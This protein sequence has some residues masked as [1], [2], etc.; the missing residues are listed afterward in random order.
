MTPTFIQSIRL[1]DI[2]VYHQDD[3]GM[4]SRSWWNVTGMVFCKSN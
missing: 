3:I 1:N 4:P 2:A